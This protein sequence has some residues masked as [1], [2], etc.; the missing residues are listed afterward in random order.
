VQKALSLKD[1]EALGVYNV[2]EALYEKV[3]EQYNQNNRK[4][5]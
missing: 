1:G 2:G 5:S 3:T 4:R